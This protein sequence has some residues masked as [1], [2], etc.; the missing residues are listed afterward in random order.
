[1]V[2]R[3]W[4]ESCKLGNR[5]LGRSG[6]GARLGRAG[7]TG[8]AARRKANRHSRTRVGAGMARSHGFD[9][10][11]AEVL[12]DL[13]AMRP[14][15]GK[16]RNRDASG[17]AFSALRSPTEHSARISPR[18]SRSGPS[19]GGPPT[20]LPSMPGFGPVISPERAR[21][22]RARTSLSPSML[23]LPLTSTEARAPNVR[24]HPRAPSMPGPRS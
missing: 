19:K 17:R 1:M 16:G 5:H 3:V 4:A 10:V 8:G 21:K 22:H 6:L 12:A 20:H 14:M 11:R 7:S 15:G 24:R 23:V 13:V 18:T 9:G 2:R